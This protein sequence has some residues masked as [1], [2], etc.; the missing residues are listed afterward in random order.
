MATQAVCF[1]IVQTVVVLI[2][3][4]FSIVAI[5]TESWS[6]VKFTM[7]LTPP[8]TAPSCKTQHICFVFDEGMFTVTEKSIQVSPVSVFVLT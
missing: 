6:Q 8:S 7:D 5:A 1:Q 2:A 4:V 3:L